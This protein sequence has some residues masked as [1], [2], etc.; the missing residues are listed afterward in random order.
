MASPPKVNREDIWPLETP[1][2][3]KA[4]GITEKGNQTYIPSVGDGDKSAKVESG[5]KTSSPGKTADN[6]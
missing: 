2:I 1:G 3:G 5:K 4:Q 6:A